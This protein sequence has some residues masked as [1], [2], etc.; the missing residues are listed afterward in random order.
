MTTACTRCSQR[1]KNVQRIGGA[2]LCPDCYRSQLAC[3]RVRRY[4][5][6]LA[7]REIEDGNDMSMEEV[8]AMI[9][10]QQKCLPAWWA[11]EA[12]RATA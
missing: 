6:R 12:E 11:R 7:E 8:E 4:R 3:A 5:Q 10:E 9:A 1:T 2:A